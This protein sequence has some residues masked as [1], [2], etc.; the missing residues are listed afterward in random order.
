MRERGARARGRC[1]AGAP[2]ATR[3]RTFGLCEA[4][5]L[6]CGEDAHPG[7]GTEAETPVASPRPKRGRQACPAS[8]NLPCRWPTAASASTKTSASRTTE[9]A[10]GGREK[11]LP[12]RCPG[13]QSSAP[14]PLRISGDLLRGVPEAIPGLGLRFLLVFV[15]FWFLF[16]CF[17]LFFFLGRG[18][19]K[20]S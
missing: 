20:G 7:S 5:G 13:Y 19:G 11:Q 3:N 2:G 10:T 6:P 12:G 16:V 4:S 1:P 9:P 8:P 14:T 15:C 18:M 17:L